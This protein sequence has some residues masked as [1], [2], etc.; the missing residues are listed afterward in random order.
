MTNFDYEAL[1]LKA[2]IEIHQQLNTKEKLFSHTPTIIRDSSE[3]TGEVKRY[4]RVATSEMGDVD[5]AAK[6]EMLAARLF[7][8]Y[9]YDTTGL[10]EI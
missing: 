8:Y 3:H 7:T 4:L 2:G 10:V 1:G 6:E 5:R 9:T